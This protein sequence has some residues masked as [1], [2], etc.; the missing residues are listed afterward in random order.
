MYKLFLPI[1]IFVI[2]S[3]SLPKETFNKLVKFQ[4][5]ITEL[6]LDY[7]LS[8]PAL[9]TGLWNNNYDAYDRFL[10]DEIMRTQSGISGFING[11]YYYNCVPSATP[12]VQLDSLTRIDD[13]SK[14]LG[15]WKIVYNR[16]IT[17][18]DSVSY[19]DYSI[20]RTIRKKKTD[21]EADM[22]LSLTD[23]RFKL[24][25]RT[26]PNKKFTLKHSKKYRIVNGRY[27]MLYNLSKAGAAINFIGIDNEGRLI[28]EAFI[29]QERSVRGKYQVFHATMAQF[30]FKKMV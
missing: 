7:G 19:I 18:E 15:D 30:I 11:V 4:Y 17:F 1:L 28:L 25:G 9:D 26:N 23:K 14:T 24:Y 27:I 8:L 10:T 22:I 3:C 6:P 20:D 12:Y 29:Q 2:S 13:Y 5:D 16:T 21:E